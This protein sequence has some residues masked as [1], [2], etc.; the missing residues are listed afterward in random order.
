MGSKNIHDF[1]LFV[2]TRTRSAVLVSDSGDDDD[3]IWL[4]LSQIEID[5]DVLDD[6]TMVGV[7]Q[8]LAEDKGLV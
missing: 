6:W 8:W 2:H 4:P 1:N 3:G 5:E 7:P